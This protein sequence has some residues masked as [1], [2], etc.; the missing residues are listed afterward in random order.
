MKHARGYYLFRGLYTFLAYLPWVLIEA[1]SYVIA[2]LMYGVVRYRRS[3]VATNLRNSFPDKTALELRELSWDFYYHL[4][5]QFVST[6]KILSQSAEVVKAK[7]LFLSGQEQLAEDARAGAKAIILLLGHCGNWEVFSAA[8]LY[9]KEHGLQT[10]QLYRPLDNKAFDE[11]QLA[12][13]TRFGATTTVKGEIGRKLIEQIRNPQSEVHAIAF[14][15]DQTPGR[16]HIGLWTTFLHQ[17]TPWLDGAERLARKYGLPVYY[18]DIR[19][20]SNR[21][22]SGEF[23]CITKDASQTQAKEITKRFASLLEESIK[24]D[25]AIWLWSHKRWKHLPHPNDVIE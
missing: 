2:A 12:L 8:N 5:H 13:R 7:H 10:E 16:P 1:I 23:V 9:L 11:V 22:Y 24:R 18:V 25:P 19:R 14:I 21:K 3:V 20:L 17:P 6:P 15:G 4:A